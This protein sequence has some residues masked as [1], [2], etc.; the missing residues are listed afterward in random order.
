M[1][2]DQ[3]LLQFWLG[4]RYMELSNILSNAFGLISFKHKTLQLQDLSR[5]SLPSK[6]HLVGEKKKITEYL[7][8]C[9]IQGYD[10]SLLYQGAEIFHSRKNSAAL[11]KWLPVNKLTL[12]LPGLFRNPYFTSCPGRRTTIQPQPQSCHRPR[13]SSLELSAIRAEWVKNEKRLTLF[14]SSSTVLLALT[15][16]SVHRMARST[17]SE[18]KFLFAQS[19][20]ASGIYQS[21]TSRDNGNMWHVYHPKLLCGWKNLK[22]NPT[23]WNFIKYSK[24]LSCIL[25]FEQLYNGFQNRLVLLINC[26]CIVYGHPLDDPKR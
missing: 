14:I 8:N 23:K 22:L 18:L 3:L 12:W 24:E 21:I 6:H 2:W 1:F 16:Q 10:E 11:S 19:A 25:P 17:D 5:A 9:L 7:F 20:F 4:D 15:H 13:D 26:L